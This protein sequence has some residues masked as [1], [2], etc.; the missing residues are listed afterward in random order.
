MNIRACFGLSYHPDHHYIYPAPIDMSLEIWMKVIFFSFIATA[1]AGL[2]WS[3]FYFCL[4]CE[5]TSIEMISRI[6]QFRTDSGLQRPC[7]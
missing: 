3:C 2:A 1:I 5:T 7:R 4:K 6:Q